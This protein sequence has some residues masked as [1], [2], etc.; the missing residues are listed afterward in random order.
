MPSP[1]GTRHTDKLPD[2]SLFNES[3]KDR[4]TFDNWLVQVKN[5]LQGNVDS[6]STEDLKII[7][8]TSQVSSNALTLIFLQLEALNSHVYD[9]MIE[10][11]KY[12]YKLYSDLN[13]ECN[14]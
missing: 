14:V 10:L 9:T 5:K 1:K 8:T 2:P 4:P 11:Y 7:Y 12:L 6:Y 13:K 3:S